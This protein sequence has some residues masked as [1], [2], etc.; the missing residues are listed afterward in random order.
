MKSSRSSLTGVL[1]IASP[2]LAQAQAQAQRIAAARSGHCDRHARGHGAVRYDDGGRRDPFGALVSR[3]ANSSRARHDASAS[4]LAS[5]ALADVT[6]RGI[7]SSG[8]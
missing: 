1:A 6:V 3:R 5:M 4:G 2:A 8:S 7:V